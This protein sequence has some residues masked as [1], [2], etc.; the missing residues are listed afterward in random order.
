ME[1][2]I[3][4][5]PSDSAK[6]ARHVEHRLELQEHGV[7]VL[8]RQFLVGRLRGAVLA[9]GGLA[10]RPASVQGILPAL[11]AHACNKNRLYTV[12]IQFQ[13]VQ[14]SVQNQLSTVQSWSHSEQNKFSTVQN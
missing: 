14:Y 6:I 5:L 7:K 11:T 2:D 13:T 12:H 8:E 3:G 9:A 1:I 10:A 4:S